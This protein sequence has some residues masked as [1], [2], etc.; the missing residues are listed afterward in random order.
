MGSMA[1]GGRLHLLRL[2]CSVLG[3]GAGLAVPAAASTGGT[4]RRVAGPLVAHVNSQSFTDATGDNQGTAPDIVSLTVAN[5]DRGIITFRI[6]FANRAELLADDFVLIYLDTDND[7]DTGCPPASEYLI[8]ARGNEAYL[9][10]CPG[11]HP[12]A[13]TPQGQLSHTF[14][15]GAHELQISLNR[16]DI[17]NPSGFRILVSASGESNQSFDFAGTSVIDPWIYQVVAPPDVAAPHVKAFASTGRH[18]ATAG[19]FYTLS[20]ASGWSREKVR[21]LRGKVVVFAHMTRPAPFVE[22]RH[23][24]VQ[25]KVP[26]SVQGTFRFCVQAWDP[27]GNGS[28]PVC[29]RLTI[30]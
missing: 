23:Y 26:R 19:L 9:I 11:G 25:W 1:C 8:A 28:A 4:E 17:G 13:T 7:L 2:G 12:D 3:L 20:D 16:F 10:H 14:D 30:R 18:G 29:A 6:A 22:G 27:A 21:V 15:P 5:D 24:Q